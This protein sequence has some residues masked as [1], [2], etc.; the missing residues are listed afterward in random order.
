MS[1]PQLPAD[2]T[3]LAFV[4]RFGADPELLVRAPGRVNLIGEFTDFNGGFCLPC[5]IDRETVVAAR[6][7]PD[8]VVH[9]VAVD[10]GHAEDRFALS[11]PLKSVASPKWANYVRGVFAALQARGLSLG[12]VDL[13]VAGKHPAGRRAE[14]V[15]VPRDRRRR[16]LAP[17]VQFADRRH[18]LGKSGPMGRA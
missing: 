7:R 9:V 10:A 3:R 1:G 6:A 12:G 5:A 11:A 18:R 17:V 13:A 4:R 16:S 15:G 14:F 2:R 8:D